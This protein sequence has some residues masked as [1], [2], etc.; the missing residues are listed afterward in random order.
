[1]TYVEVSGNIG[2][3]D[4]ASA[5][6]TTLIDFIKPEQIQRL[7]MHSNTI[8][9]GCT[10]YY[11]GMSSGAWLTNDGNPQEWMGYGSPESA[12]TAP[13]GSTYQRVDGGYQRYTKL[14]GSGNTGWQATAGVVATGTIVC[15]AKASLAD[16]DY[17]TI[18]DGLSAPK[19]YEF[20]TAGDGVTSGRVQVNVS[21]DTSA[22][23]VGDRLKT[24]IEA[25]QPA[26]SVVNASGT[27][28]ITHKI[29]GL[30][31]N[32]SI[33]ENVANAGFTVSGM[34]GGLDPVR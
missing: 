7:V 17:C 8:L 15:V 16:T 22:T 13:V 29:A 20:D 12:V 31:G 9:G 19:L 28:T 23:Q 2:E 30:L 27:L 14:S 32:V 3:D 26:L 33:T 34:S 1:M 11:T 5:T 25:N 18:G 4:Q 21:T 10:A 6:M 24:A